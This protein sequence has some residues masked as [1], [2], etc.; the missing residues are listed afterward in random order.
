MKKIV[1]YISVVLFMLLLTTPLVLTFFSRAVLNRNIDV[2][3]NGNF[4]NYFFPEIRPAAFLDGSFQNEFQEWWSNEFS[5]KNF[6]TKNYN[7]IQYSVFHHLGE[8]SGIEVGKDNVLFEKIYI[9]EYL[10]RGDAFDYSLQDNIDNMQNFVSE[11]SELN[12]KLNER[13]IALLVYTA[14]VKS[15]CLNDYFPA[16]TGEER[17]EQERGIDV[18]REMIAKRPQIAYLDGQKYIE[19]NLEKSIPVFYK[20]GSHWSRPAEQLVTL[21]IWNRLRDL[22]GLSVKQLEIGRLEKSDKPY[23]RDSDIFDL[24]NVW[25][26]DK[27]EVYYQYEMLTMDSGDFAEPKILLQGDSFAVGFGKE[28]YDRELG[29]DL[30][31][32]NYDYYYTQNN[33]GA[34]PIN[35][36]D[37]IDFEAL[38]D[39]LDIVIVETTNCNIRSYSSGFVAYLNDYL[40]K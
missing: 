12:D 28:F 2:A 21:E 38:L 36:F 34:N 25:Y 37:D 17:T 26:G 22:T 20:T 23:W 13:G 39:G 10:K 29:T 6:L 27:D 4:D 7:Q 30:T 5:G 3:M 1:N 8:N 33:G 35:G 16:L 40:D 24:M 18:F 19:E 14:P 15:D 9:D 11:L 31:Y 32:I